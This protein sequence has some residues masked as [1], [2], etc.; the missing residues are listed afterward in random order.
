[1]RQV[2][3]LLELAQNGNDQAYIELINL[4]SPL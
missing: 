1:M 2:Q 4:I 3:I